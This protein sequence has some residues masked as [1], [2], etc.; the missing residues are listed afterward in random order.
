M[1]SVVV[2]AGAED[3]VPDALGE[4]LGAGAEGQRVRAG[5]PG[6]VAGLRSPR[7]IA[8]NPRTKQAASPD[9]NASRNAPAR[10]RQ[11][12]IVALGSDRPSPAR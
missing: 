6:P 8:L 1:R 5:H 4:H 12:V 9:P 10:P 7:R 11:S 2:N 3:C